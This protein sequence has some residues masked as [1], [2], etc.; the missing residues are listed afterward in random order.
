VIAGR[1]VVTDENP[2]FLAD[3]P[4]P[5]R[6]FAELAER[7]DWSGREAAFAKRHVKDMA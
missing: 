6:I 5:A 1:A 3:D 2:A 7:W 4:N